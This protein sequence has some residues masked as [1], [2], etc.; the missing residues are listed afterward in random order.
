MN[1][2]SL[3]DKNDFELL[4]IIN[5]AKKAIEDYPENPNNKCYQDKINCCSDELYKRRKKYKL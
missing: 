4:N 2:K 5:D 1:N 3:K